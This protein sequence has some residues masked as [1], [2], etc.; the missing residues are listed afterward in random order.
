MKLKKEKLLKVMSPVLIGSLI[1]TPVAPA[2]SVL[3]NSNNKVETSNVTEKGEENNLSQKLI[4]KVDSLIVIKDQL[5][6]ISEE[7]LAKLTLKEQ[8]Q[9]RQSIQEVN[10]S[11]I[12]SLQ[13]SY[14]TVN[15]SQKT[16]T[17]SVSGNPTSLFQTKKSPYV[18]VY[19]KWWG[20]QIQFSH[21]AVNDLND[22]L[23]IGGIVGGL[24]AAKGISKF[25]A[26][27][28]L[29]LA[30]KFLGPISLFGSGVAWAMS[31]VDRGRGVSLNCVMYVP[32]TI[33]AR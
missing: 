19:Y 12:E 4:D 29:K 31:K 26:K 6:Y 16:I 33:T 22:Y 25:L 32:A 21:K 24:G 11:I 13:S 23:A 7:N 5:F 15:S 9:I 10:A 14:I 1:F 18:A 2:V 27:N 30:A 20:A 3:A 28:G 17:T 8:K